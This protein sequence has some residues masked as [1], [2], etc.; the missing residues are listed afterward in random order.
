MGRMLDVNPPPH[1]IMPMCEAKLQGIDLVSSAH[2]PPL[3]LAQAT[4]MTDTPY[5]S[6]AQDL[7]DGG[8]G[9]E[10]LRDLRVH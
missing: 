8:E 4:K 5:G 10:R 9:L 2:L 7:Q 3:Q 1:H 6:M